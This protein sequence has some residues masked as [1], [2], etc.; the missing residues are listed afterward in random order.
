MNSLRAFSVVKAATSS[1]GMPFRTASFSAISGMYELSF[2]FPRKGTG[3]RYGESVS[4]TI[5]SS[6]IFLTVSAIPAFLYVSTPP[7]PMY[8]SPYP[9]ILPNVEPAGKPYLHFESR[10]LF[11]YEFIGPVAVHP[12]FSDGQYFPA[13]TMFHFFHFLFPSR[14]DRSGMKSEA[15]EKV[16]REFSGQF[17]HRLPGA[18]V[19]I[20][21]YH[22]RDSGAD[23]PAHGIFRPVFHKLFIIQMSVSVDKMHSQSV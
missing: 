15:G 8:Q 17:E 1:T 6:G 12:D 19:Y 10:F 21:Q 5:L 18:S 22:F 7:I 3:V 2:L 16:L 13:G 23:G 11:P 14:S 20:R 9:D 4:R